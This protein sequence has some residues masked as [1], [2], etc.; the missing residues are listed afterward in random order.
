MRDFSNL[1]WRSA[2]PKYT[3]A[4]KSLLEGTQL[5]LTANSTILSSNGKSRIGNR[6]NN[7]IEH[8]LSMGY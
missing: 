5:F 2:F 6:I 3:G 8:H 7:N 4:L 1:I